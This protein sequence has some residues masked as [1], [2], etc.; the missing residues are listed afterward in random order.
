MCQ[1]I[2]Q[3]DW[4]VDRVPLEGTYITKGTYWASFNDVIDIEEK[5]EWIKKEELGGAG[6]F[7]MTGDDS[8][9]E[10]GCGEFPL[11]KKINEVF[12]KKNDSIKKCISSAMKK[13]EM[14]HKNV[15]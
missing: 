3:G 13:I 14:L 2:N 12:F 6:V 4:F 11:L 15:N 5:A 8:K 1:R 9:N 10:C 7:L